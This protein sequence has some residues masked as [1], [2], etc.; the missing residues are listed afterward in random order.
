MPFNANHF[1]SF[2]LC[3][4]QLAFAM[5]YQS[6]F[7][8]LLLSIPAVTA[9]NCSASYFQSLIPSNAA[10]RFA[11]PV[12]NGSTFEVPAGDIA[13]PISPTHM[14][15]ACAVEINVT[16]SA[17]SAFSFGLF[18]PDAS[19]WN[20]RFLAVGNG[21]FA[22]GINWLDMASGLGYGFSVM[23][24][25][26]GHNSTSGDVTWA[27]NNPERQKDFGYRA[28]HGSIVLAKQITEAF[29]G[30]HPKYSYY[31]GCST[32]G[33]QGLKELQIH[34]E[35][36]DG[37][38]AGAPAWWTSHLQTW[39]LKV[40]LFNLPVDADHHISPE[41]FPAIARE[42]LKQ[43]DTQDGVKDNIISDPQ[44]CNFFPEALLCGP[45]VTNQTTSACLTPP[46]VKTLYKLHGDYVETNDTFIFPGLNLG[47]EAQW[48]FLLGAS[49]PSTYGTQYVQD[50]VLNDANWNYWDF[51]VSIVELA[52][53]R[54][55]GNATADD[56]DLSPFHKRGGKLIHYHGDSD[57][58][59]PTGSSIYFYKQVLQT[60][61]SKGIDLGGWYRFFLIPGM[62]HC[63]GTPTNM[64]APW[65]IAGGNQAGELGTSPNAVHSVPGFSDGRH[66]ALLALMDWV[67]KGQAP[68]E[69]IATKWKND[70]AGALEVERQ[71]PLCPYPTQARYKGHGNVGDASSW[72]CAS[73]YDKAA[74]YAEPEIMMIG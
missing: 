26:T 13:Y 71:R 28:M 32:G 67:E 2:L 44:G 4:P 41:L 11:R 72:H 39:T 25:D 15:A 66:D 68:D 7:S 56:F 38:L 51:N 30:K 49:D 16:S 59:I 43:C 9:A 18:L 53:S 62:Q 40:A 58:L 70:T 65:Y 35:T 1:L 33:R 69:I 24:T 21:G 6:Y 12:I 3:L 60:L 61:K 64:D 48:D 10:V 47:S 8:S 50:M 46:Q 31:S 55:P 5:R 37:V 27:L 17:E 19:T 45:N 42:V 20:S 63:S 52:D 23:S 22:G 34:P 73:L 14:N 57:G 54:R 74:H 29:Y 36:F